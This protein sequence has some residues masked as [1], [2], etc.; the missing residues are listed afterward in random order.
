LRDDFEQISDGVDRA[1]TV[2]GGGII[3]IIKALND[4]SNLIG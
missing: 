4:F 1:M 2:V 3:Q